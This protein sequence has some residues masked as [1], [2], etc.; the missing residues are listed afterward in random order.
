MPMLGM[1]AEAA[2]DHEDA[3]GPLALIMLTRSSCS[4]SRT[5]RASL[6]RSSRFGCTGRRRAVDRGAGLHQSHGVE[7]MVATP[8]RLN[9]ALDRDGAQPVQLRRARR[10]RQDDRPRLRAADQDDPRGD[11]ELEPQA[12]RRRRARRPRRRHDLPA[13]V[14]VLGDDAAGGRADREDVHAQP[15]YVYIGD[16]ASTKETTQTII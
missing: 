16:Q 13:D 5:R 1:R 11:A 3:R 2:A 6:R 15:A 12:R 8:G 10:G 14:H 9:D 7:V 4:K